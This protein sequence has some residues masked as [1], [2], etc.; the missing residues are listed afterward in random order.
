M[1]YN[2]EK[3][4]EYKNLNQYKYESDLEIRSVKDCSNQQ[5]RNH[6]YQREE[7]SGQCEEN[8]NFQKKLL[9]SQSENSNQ[10]KF[11]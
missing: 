11:H 1:H 9:Q 8:W 5:K 3:Y 10:R 4:L 6:E 2:Q 7:N